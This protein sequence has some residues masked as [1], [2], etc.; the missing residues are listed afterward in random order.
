MA[1]GLEA[2]AWKGA[3]ERRQL[4][5]RMLQPSPEA[6]LQLVLHEG[7]MLLLLPSDLVAALPCSTLRQLMADS[8]KIVFVVEHLRP[9]GTGAQK[10][11]EHLSQ[12]R[13]ASAHTSPTL[14]TQGASVEHPLSARRVPRRD[15]QHRSTD[16]TFGRVGSC[17]AADT[18]VPQTLR[19][20]HWLAKKQHTTF[21]LKEL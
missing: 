5:Q 3:H 21:E 15:V 9:Y 1:D 17:Q 13:Y 10:L 4:L 20:P 8:V 7:C 12:R 2:L 18:S 14:L 19:V 6:N 16:C 11:S